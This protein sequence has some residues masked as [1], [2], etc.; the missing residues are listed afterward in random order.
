[1]YTYIQIDRQIDRQID[2]QILDTSRP[3]NRDG[4]YQ[5]ETKCIVTTNQILIQCS[6]LIPLLKIEEVLCACVCGGGGGGG[7]GGG[8]GEVE[9]AGKAEAR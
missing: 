7:G 1:M 4:S 8:V 5:G 9:W 3:V 2:Q 6:R